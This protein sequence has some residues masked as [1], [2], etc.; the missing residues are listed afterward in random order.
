MKA[1]YF[2]DHGSVTMAKQINYKNVPFSKISSMMFTQT[3]H[4]VKYK[5]LHRPG[6]VLTLNL[7]ML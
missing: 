4:D 2:K 3:L 7:I 5:T 1:G 6:N